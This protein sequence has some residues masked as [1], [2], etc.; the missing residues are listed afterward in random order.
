[1]KKK[2]KY[3]IGGSIIL[4]SLFINFVFSEKSNFSKI[5]FDNIDALAEGESGNKPK[6]TCIYTGYICTGVDKDGTI[7]TFHG[8]S[9]EHED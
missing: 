5:I 4:V 6:P 1:M 7:G 2:V 8:L 3:L 9:S